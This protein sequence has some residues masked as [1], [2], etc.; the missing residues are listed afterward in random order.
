[1][2]HVRSASPQSPRK[3][4]RAARGRTVCAGPLTWFWCQ[5]LGHPPSR[6]CKCVLSRRLCSRARLFLFCCLHLFFIVLP[7]SSFLVVFLLILP[8]TSFCFHSPNYLFSLCGC[9]RSSPRVCDGGCANVIHR[10]WRCGAPQ[11]RWS[12]CAISSGWGSGSCCFGMF[13]Q[14]RS[15]P[16]CTHPVRVSGSCVGHRRECLGAGGRVV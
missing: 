12:S 3:G 9:A 2:R 16:A 13:T 8:V 15:R 14:D 10:L 1:M 5:M 11:T 7:A 4:C 6:S